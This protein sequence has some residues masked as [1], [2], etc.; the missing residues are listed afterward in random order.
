VVLEKVIRE[1][2]IGPNEGIRLQDK[3]I[4]L[5]AY[6]DDIVLMEESQDRL[7][8]LFSRLHK[9]AS[10]V[11]LCV[12]E[13]KTEYMFLS[14]KGLPFCQSIKIDQY[15]FKWVEQFKYL[16]SILSEKNNESIE[17]AAKIQA[18][19]KC[20][21]GLTNILC[22]QAVSRRLKEQLYTSLI[23]PVV[24]YESE[25]WPLRKMDE[26][27]FLVFERKVL[28]KIYG[29]V[30]DEITGEWRRRKNLELEALYSS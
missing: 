27:R 5:L 24:V 20:Y 16:G 6:A 12:N 3:S 13:E 21:Y 23:R 19:N 22:S 7:K 17:V 10:K 9:A 4:G 25:T 11:G 18:G 15:E 29:P 2:K 30:K 1:I 26:Q 14:R 8:I 28:R